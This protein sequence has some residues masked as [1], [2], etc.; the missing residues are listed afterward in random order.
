MTEYQMVIAGMFFFILIAVALILFYLRYKRHITMQELEMS[1]A[2]TNHQRALLQAVILSQEK[3]RKRI[4]M[5][6]HDEVG[7]ALSSLRMV[8]ANGVE[9]SGKAVQQC[10]S[11]I[12]QVLVDVRNISHDLSP[13]LQG[14]YT[15]ADAI[16]D[17]CE[18]VNQ[19]G[20]IHVHLSF[21]PGPGSFSPD[22]NVSLALYRVLS[23]LINNTIKHAQAKNI[24][25]RFSLSGNRSEVEY[26]DD[27]IGLHQNQKKGMGMQNIESRL[28]MIGAE[29]H[30]DH[31]AGRGFHID[32]KW[33]T[34]FQTQ[35]A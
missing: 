18:A 4:G 14:A 26:R 9:G 10:K 31:S 17:R 1:R 13:I 27:G 34:T 21:D 20:Q 2:E 16:E 24:H 33:N 15:L 19:S 7:S 11:I 35:T 22:E 23:E 30:I 29:F 8:M 6:L 3:E 25:I 12:D 32:I 5:N 28:N